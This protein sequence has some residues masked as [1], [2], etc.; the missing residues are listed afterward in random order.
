[1]CFVVLVLVRILKGKQDDGEKLPVHT[2]ENLKKR[3]QDDGDKY[4]PVR[5]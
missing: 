3:K 1:M 2:H 5:L 4:E